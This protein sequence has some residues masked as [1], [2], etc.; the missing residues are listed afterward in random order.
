MAE[1]TTNKYITVAYKLFVT[2][3]DGISEM[4]EEATTERPFE[5]VSG[6]GLALDAFEAKV[7]PLAKG[8]TFDFE[9]SIDEGYGPYVEEGVQRLPRSVFEIDGRIDSRY[10]FEG[11]IVPLMNADGERFNATITRITPEEI[12]VDLNHPWAGKT[13][14]FV[15]GVTENRE[16]TAAE[17]QK[18][19]EGLSG[20]CGD[21]SSGN[22]GGGCG[23]CGGCG[24]K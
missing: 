4:V 12:T 6:M 10:I 16:A 17:M 19:V 7:T 15:G 20:C 22:C 2:G 14:R 1:E 5:F 21:C 18:V 13:L 8:E 9:L 24:S 23:G 3:A 11:A